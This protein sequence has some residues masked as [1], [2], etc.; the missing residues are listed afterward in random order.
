MNN[1]RNELKFSYVA[2]Y[3]NKVQATKTTDEMLVTAKLW[4][5]RS[6]QNNN[7]CR[8]QR[9]Q[10]PQLLFIKTIFS[11]WKCC[12]SNLTGFLKKCWWSTMRHHH[13]PLQT[14]LP[15]PF[16]AYGSFAFQIWQDSNFSLV[17]HNETSHHFPFRLLPLLLYSSTLSAEQR[18]NFFWINHLWQ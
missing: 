9:C 15:R 11:I 2:N 17:E 13:F 4:N 14:Y 6:N 1:C 18:I 10:P 16:S 8:I 12:F 3:T 7:A 5:L